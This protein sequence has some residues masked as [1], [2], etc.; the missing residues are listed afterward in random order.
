MMV[1]KKNLTFNV[2]FTRLPKRIHPLATYFQPPNNGEWK[3]TIT[4][5][6]KKCN[7]SLMF[8]LMKVENLFWKVCKLGKILSVMSC[9]EKRLLCIFL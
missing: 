8:M 9:S 7:D 2:S 6:T 1:L 3:E 5:N 4:Q